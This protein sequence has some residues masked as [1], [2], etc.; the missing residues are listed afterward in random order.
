[1]LFK[2]CKGLPPDKHLI[3]KARDMIIIPALKRKKMQLRDAENNL[4]QDPQGTWSPGSL[5]SVP[6]NAS[7]CLSCKGEDPGAWM[8][9]GFSMQLLIC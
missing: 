6:S 1:M 5:N 9:A 8:G 2:V 7:P 4:A 3:Y